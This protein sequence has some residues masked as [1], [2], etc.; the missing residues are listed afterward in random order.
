[1]TERGIGAGALSKE[2]F[3]GG[4]AGF[5]GFSGYREIGKEG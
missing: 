5:R 4:K 2:G 3:L 1:M